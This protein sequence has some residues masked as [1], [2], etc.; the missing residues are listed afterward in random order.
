M[1]K[2]ILNLFNNKTSQTPIWLMRQA[3]RYLP[4]Y[5]ELRSNKKGF[6]DLC[7]DPESASEVTLQPIRRFNLDAAIIFSDILVIPDSMGIKVEFKEAEGPVLEKIKSIEDLK[8]EPKGE[9]LNLVYEAIEITKRQLPENVALIG[10]SGSPWTIAAYMVEGKLSK[11]LSEVKSAYYNNRK[12]FDFLIE[13][14]IEN[15]AQHL[16]NQI[17]HGA[18]IV[19]LFDSW[20]GMLID[21]DYKNLVIKPNQ[22]IVAKVKTVYPNIPII[23]FPRMSFMQYE[24][25]CNEVNCDAIGIDQYMNLE[26]IKNRSNG[27]IIQGN[28]DPL[29]LLSK[30]QDLIKERV[31]KILKAM[32]N[33]KFIFNLGHGVVPKTPAENVEY[34][35]NYVKGI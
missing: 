35:V 5:R 23:C 26:W 32:K 10:F 18:E 3:G 21:D 16:I 19:Q 14:L 13:T 31:D 27:K 30:S 24:I 34:L 7:Y 15:I 4:E 25:F 6:L 8:R 1:K 17:K 29:V 2:T 22:K 12:F 33:E 20:A 28:L 11:D 9:K